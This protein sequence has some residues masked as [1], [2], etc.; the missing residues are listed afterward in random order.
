[1]KNNNLAYIDGQNLHLATTKAPDP[2]Q[3]DLRRF[4]VYL[5]RKYHVKEAYYFIGAFDPDLQGLYMSIQKSGD[6]LIFREH[7][8]KLTG[9]K[10]GNVDVDIVFQIMRTLVEEPKCGKTIIVSGDGDYKRMVDYLIE[11]E[12]FEK[13]L[14]PC[15]KYGSSLY[16]SLGSEYYDHIDTASVRVKF[17][18]E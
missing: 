4:R 3:V 10:K 5:E 15:R 6:I 8:I 12:K 18:A 9:R 11:K 17:S 16:K 7:A 1:M 13:L 2:W 14:I